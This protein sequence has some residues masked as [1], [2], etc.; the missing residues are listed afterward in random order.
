MGTDMKRLFIAVL[1]LLIPGLACAGSQQIKTVVG[2]AKAAGSTP[3]YLYDFEESGAPTGWTTN[4]GTPDY[5][6]TSSPLEGSESLLLAGKTAAATT[7]VNMPLADLTSFS[8]SF[9]LNLQ[10]TGG[11]ASGSDLLG[12]VYDGTTTLAT[13]Y[14]VYSSST[15]Y[16]LRANAEGGSS[17]TTSATISVGSTYLVCVDYA[18]GTGSNAV[19][20]IGFVAWTGSETCPT[21][22]TGFASSTNGTRQASNPADKLRFFG[23][24]ASSTDCFDTKIDG[25]SEL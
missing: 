20:S 13:Y 8:R 22:G 17:A 21:S 12:T 23:T 4:S 6:N 9:L 2:M 5:D 18:A 1:L 16:N 24:Y 15:T 11:G 3:T 7:S 10:T 19:A 14:Y 25:I